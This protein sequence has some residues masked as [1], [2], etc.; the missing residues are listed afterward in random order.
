MRCSK[1]ARVVS[2]FILA[3]AVLC[4]AES[5][6]DNLRNMPNVSIEGERQ[7]P[8]IFFV[9]PTG[10]GGNL[11]APRFRDYGPDI[12][13]PLVKPWFERDQLVNPI[14]VQAASGPKMDWQELFKAEPAAAAPEIPSL[15][16]PGIPSIATH[17]PPR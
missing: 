9:F 4:A 12:L 6:E 10:K 3:G 8:D 13:D 17:P 1:S 5:R 2:L 11:S 7:T 14:P 16:E 15:R